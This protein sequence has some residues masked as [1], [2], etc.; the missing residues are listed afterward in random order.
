MKEKELLANW[1][2][3]FSGFGNNH[4]ITGSP[5]RTESRFLFYDTVNTFYIAEGY[6]LHKKNTQIRQSQMLDYLKEHALTEIHPFYK[7]IS[8]E[9]GVQSEQLFWQIR[10]YIPANTTPRI[11]LGKRG[12]FGCLWGDFLLRMKDVIASASTPPPMPNP[13]FFI[14][15]FLPRLSSLAER[16]MPFII[17]R[18]QNI[19]QKL[20]PFLKWERKV[21]FEFA[22]GDYHP[23]NILMGD[24]RINAVIDWEFSGAKFPG[25]DMALLIGCLAMDHPDNLSSPAVCEFQNILYRNGYLQDDVWENLPSMIAATRLGWLGEWLNMEEE[26]LVMQELELLS[27]LL[28]D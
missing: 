18:L 25:Y 11:E 3:T 1:N 2:I 16:K 24:D 22:H 4:L 14:G 9:Y 12:D 21:E 8:S 10:P 19:K 28:D 20:I 17:D 15:D 26:S 6:P 7:T 5:N 23:G 27:I 13:P